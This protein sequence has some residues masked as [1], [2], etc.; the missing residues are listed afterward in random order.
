M[1]LARRLFYFFHT[2][3]SLPTRQ[4]FQPC[5]PLVISTLYCY[6]E[7]FSKSSTFPAR[8]SGVEERRAL[9]R[10]HPVLCEDPASVLPS[11]APTSAY[12]PGKRF[13]E[14]TRAAPTSA[15]L[16]GEFLRRSGAYEN[17]S[18]LTGM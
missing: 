8:L 5:F 14:G 6:F 1:S 13:P 3:S 10:F 17:V 4:V 15:S 11:A 7:A 16:R 12:S 18:H 9:G 2:L